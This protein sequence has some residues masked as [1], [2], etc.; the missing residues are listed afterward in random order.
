MGARSADPTLET[1]H[2]KVV[3]TTFRDQNLAEIG[4]TAGEKLALVWEPD[5]EHGTRL[6][7]GIGA[8]VKVCRK[9]GHHLGYLP[10]STAP[11]ASL[12]A[13]HLRSGGSAHAVVSELTG[14]TPD[15]PSIGINLEIWLSA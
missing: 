11:T 12:V 10:D 2:S 4:L 9:D 6:A 7:D 3:G 13:R 8:A 14:G 5:N 15:K 1:W